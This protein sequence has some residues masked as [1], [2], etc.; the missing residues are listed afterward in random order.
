MLATCSLV[1]QTRINLA[2]TKSRQ[3]KKDLTVI[4]SR[5]GATS[6]RTGFSKL[7][8]QLICLKGQFKD[9]TI[10]LSLVLPGSN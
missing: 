9:L 10:K 2:P 5:R 3:A 8:S 1:N 6:H 4:N 7:S